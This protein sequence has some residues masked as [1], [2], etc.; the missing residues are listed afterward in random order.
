MLMYTIYH[1]SLPGV[2]HTFSSQ[3]AHKDLLAV[4]TAKLGELKSGAAKVD[5]ALVHY[6]Q[7]WLK[8]HIKGFDMKDYG[9]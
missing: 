2:P 8:S 7:N 4:A 9:H 6:L 3:K 1:G 5:D